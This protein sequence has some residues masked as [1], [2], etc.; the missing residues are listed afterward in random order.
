MLANVAQPILQTNKQTNTIICDILTISVVQVFQ[1]WMISA[2]DVASLS[3]VAGGNGNVYTLTMGWSPLFLSQVKS[4]KKQQPKVSLSLC[5]FQA[6][7]LNMDLLS[8]LYI[9]H[10]LSSPHWPLI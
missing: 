1:L 6:F 4:P 10:F 2:I 3:S 7:Y 8:L 9:L 5:V